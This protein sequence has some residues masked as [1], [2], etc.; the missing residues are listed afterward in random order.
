MKV[1]WDNEIRNI[2]V[3]ISDGVS[4]AEIGRKYGVTGASVKKA[5]KKFG[6]KISPRRKINPNEQFN[7][8]NGKKHICLNCGVEINSYRYSKNKYCSFKCQQEFQKKQKIDEWKKNPFLFKNCGG[9]EFIRN[10]LFLKNDSRC[11]KCGWSEENHYTHKIPLQVHHVNGDCTDNREENLQLLCP[12]CHSLTETFGSSN[13][14]S[15][16]YKYKEYRSN[17]NKNRIISFINNMEKEEKEDF[18]S[19]IDL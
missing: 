6:I 12:N 8:G 15:K 5:I 13:K 18:L 9:Y 16:R 14:N 2:E 3:F 17:T 11:E 4:Y 19:K 1:N 10:Y 7:R